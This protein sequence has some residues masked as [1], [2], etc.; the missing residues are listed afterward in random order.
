MISFL[1]T[2]IFFHGKSST[3]YHSVTVYQKFCVKTN[4]KMQ[5]RLENRPEYF[6][7]VWENFLSK[8]LSGDRRGVV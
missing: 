3:F 8:L 2:T 1:F 7:R 6:D 5:N 4:L